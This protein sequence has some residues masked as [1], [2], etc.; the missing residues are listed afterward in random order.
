MRSPSQLMTRT[1]ICIQE[2]V[3]ANDP[4]V[5][6]CSGMRHCQQFR[7]FF[8]SKNSYLKIIYLFVSVQ[9]SASAND[10]GLG[11]WFRIRHCYRMSSGVMF[12]NPPL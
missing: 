4:S 1:I 10:T 2:F 12:R 3:T 11:F 6:S 9:G 8:L 5:Y 7:Y